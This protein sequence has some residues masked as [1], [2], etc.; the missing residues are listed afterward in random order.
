MDQEAITDF[1]EAF[2]EDYKNQFVE[3]IEANNQKHRMMSDMLLQTLQVLIDYYQRMAKA[4]IEIERSNY[5][6]KLDE[7]LSMR[8]RDL[9]NQIGHYELRIS[10]DGK[11]KYVRRIP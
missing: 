9:Q 7:K 11:S 2:R 8:L 6:R 4:P 1:L 5:Q 10:M 3:Y